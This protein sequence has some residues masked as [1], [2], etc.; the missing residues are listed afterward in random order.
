[1][2]RTWLRIIA[3][4]LLGCASSAFAQLYSITDLGTLGESSSQAHSINEAGQIVGSSITS[5]G[6]RHAFLWENGK[7]IDLGTLPRSPASHAR[8]IN[9]SGD[10]VGESLNSDGNLRAV[11]WRDG[12]ILDLGTF[13]GDTRS[14]AY[15]INDLGQI[16]GV[17]TPGRAVIWIEDDIHELPRSCCAT[18]GLAFSLNNRTEIVGTHWSAGAVV[19]TWHARVAGILQSGELRDDDA[20]A[21]DINESGHIVGTTDD[22]SAARAFLWRDGEAILLSEQDFGRAN[23]VNEIDQVVGR[24][25]N[26][27]FIWDDLNGLRNLQKLIVPGSGGGAS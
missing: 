14:Q 25:R 5:D 19:W 2:S 13:Q 1:M 12:Q 20:T 15:G 27:P 9:N 18:S 23:A 26:S 22:N 8:D 24:I 6:E 21:L 17:S 7:I 16:A 4:V 10:I 11:L 3:L